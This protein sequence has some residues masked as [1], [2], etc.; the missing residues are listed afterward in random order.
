[1]ELIQE[2]TDLNFLDALILNKLIDK[3]IVHQREKDAEGNITQLVEIYYKFVGM[4]VLNFKE[5]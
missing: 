4:T 3:I 2:Y 1:V 5:Q